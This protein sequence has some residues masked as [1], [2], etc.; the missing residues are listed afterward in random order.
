M[1]R[2]KSLGA[3]F[4]ELNLHDF[5]HTNAITAHI[6]TIKAVGPNIQFARAPVGPS[7][8]LQMVENMSPTKKIMLVKKKNP[9]NFFGKNEFLGRY[10]HL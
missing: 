5:I 7:W 6:L 2:K 9:K 10:F 4:V 1:K 8:N 3:D